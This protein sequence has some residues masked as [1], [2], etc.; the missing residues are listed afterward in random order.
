MITIRR[1]LTA[2]LDGWTAIIG[3]CRFHDCCLGGLVRYLYNLGFFRP[4]DEYTI[5]DGE[6]TKIRTVHEH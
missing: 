3:G 4:G 2:K 5:V 1:E 6:T